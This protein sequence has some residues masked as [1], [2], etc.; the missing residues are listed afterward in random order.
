MLAPSASVIAAAVAALVAIATSPTF[1]LLG[2]YVHL[3]RANMARGPVG[4]TRRSVFGAS[5]VQ[6]E[7]D[8]GGWL[9]SAH[10]SANGVMTHEQY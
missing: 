3:A 6:D 5:R 2:T 7:P 9:P 4:L 1:Q 10:L 8:T